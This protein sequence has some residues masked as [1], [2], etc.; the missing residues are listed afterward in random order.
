MFSSVDSKASGQ[1]MAKL[2][3]SL[4]SFL[5]LLDDPF[6]YAPKFNKSTLNAFPSFDHYMFKS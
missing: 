2:D 4:R 3:M 6:Q 1:K 5:N